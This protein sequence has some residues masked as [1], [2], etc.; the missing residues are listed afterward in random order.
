MLED[1][2]RYVL[3]RARHAVHEPRQSFED[4]RAYGAKNREI[5]NAAGIQHRRAGGRVQRELVESAAERKTQ[6][7]RR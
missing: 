5:G 6:R 1:E 2:R 4:A 3:R 7:C